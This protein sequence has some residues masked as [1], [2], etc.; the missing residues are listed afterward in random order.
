MALNMYIQPKAEIP[1]VGGIYEIVMAFEDDGYYHFLFPLFQ[2][3]KQKTGQDIDLYGNA[4]FSGL[5]L[6]DLKETIEAAKQLLVSQPKTWRVLIGTRISPTHQKIYSTVDKH[7]MN[8]VLNTMME[9]IEK[10][11]ADGSYITFWGD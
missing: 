10:A 11:K 3:L 8:K 9:A 1:R 7:Q 2:H 6:D 5:H 4:T